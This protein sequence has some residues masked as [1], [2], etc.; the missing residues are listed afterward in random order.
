MGIICRAVLMDSQMSFGGQ[1]WSSS[2]SK[3]RAQR[4]WTQQGEL[5]PWTWYG[6][7]GSPCRTD[8]CTTF[9]EVTQI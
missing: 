1:K 3:Y 7:Y 9:K 5:A 4:V 6:G 8:E 2:G